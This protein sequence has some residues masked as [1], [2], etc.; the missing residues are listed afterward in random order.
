MK[1]FYERY[2]QADPKLQRCVA[3]LP[4]RHNMLLIEKIHKDDEALLYLPQ[5]TR[6]KN[7]LKKKY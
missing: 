4:W 7:N 2:F 1:R 5:K 3:V 6:L